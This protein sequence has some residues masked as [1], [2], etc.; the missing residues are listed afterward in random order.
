MAELRPPLLDEYGLAAALGWHAEEFSRRTGIAVSVDDAARRG[1]EG[2]ARWRP[3]SRFSASRRKRSTTWLKHRAPR[4]RE[5]RDLRRRERRS[6]WR[7]AT[8][9]GA[10]TP[11]AARRG[12]WG[13]TTMRE[14]AEAA[15]GQLEVKSAPGEGTRIVA[16]VSLWL[17]HAD[18]SPDRR[19][20]CRG[21][22]G[23]APPG[24][25][26]ARHRGGGAASA[27]AARR[28]SRRATPSP[29]WC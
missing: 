9:A 4:Q 7:C 16:T 6:R 3:R 1:G 13:M 10:S 15:G 14:R 17:A 23:A 28:C 5:H 11:R 21:G 26:R 27:T 22:R 20:S 25:G 2:P 12:R 18:P 29:T 8:T 24:R 19:R